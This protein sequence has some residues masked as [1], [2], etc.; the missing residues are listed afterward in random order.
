MEQ[1]IFVSKLIPPTPVQNYLRRANLLKKLSEWEQAK[2][3]ILTSSAGYGKTSLISQFVHDQK[4]VCTWYQITSD[5]DAI[6]PFLR[7]LIVSVQQQFP[8]FGQGMTGWDAKLKFHNVEE[9][10]QLSKQLV[11]E[12]HKINQPILVV[13]DD[14]HYVSHVFS[15]N[16]VLNQLLQFL[17]KTIHLMVATRKMPEWN[18]LLKLRMNNQLIECVEQEFI[19]SE[20]DIQFLFEAYFERSLSDEECEFVM[21]MTEGWAMAVLLLAY[22][23]KHTDKQLIDIANGSVTNF[24]AFLS[25]EVFDKLES[26]VQQLLLKLSVHQLISLDVLTDIYGEKW[27]EDVQNQLSKIAFVIPLAG[28]RKYRFHALFQQFLQQHLKA[29]SPETF[30]QLHEDAAIYYAN[31][32]LGILAVTHA[33]YLSNSQLLERLLLQFAP[34][35]IEAGQFDYL[36]ERIKDIPYANKGY[37]LLYYEGES[38]RYRAHYEKAKNAYLAC[39]EL[40]QIQQDSVFMM[41]AQFGLANIY[42]DTLQ[43]VFAEGHLQ[44]AILLLE[45]AKVSDEE[46]QKINIYYT[47]NLVNLGRAGEAQRWSEEQQLSLKLNNIDARLYLRQGQLELAKETLKHR[48]A[49]PFQWEEA[50]RTTDLLLVLIDVLTGENE[51]A[52]QRIIESDKEQLIDLPFTLAITKLRKGLALLNMELS[53]STLAKRCFD[54]TL[55][56]MSQIHVKR[57]KAECY[58]GLILYYRENVKEAKRYAQLGLK[59][60]NKVQDYWMSALL[61]SAL[62]KVLVE[63]G[64]HEEAILHGKLAYTY[65]ERSEDVYGQMVISFWLTTCFYEMQDVETAQQYYNVYWEFCRNDYPFFMKKRTLFGPQRPL[66]FLHLAKNVGRQQEV[67]DFLQQAMHPDESLKLA[68]FGPVQIMHENH[69]IQDKEW[70]R[71]KAKELFLYL[72]MHRRQFVSKQQ[73]CEAIWQNDEEAMTRDFKVVYNAMLKTLEPARTAREESN[74]IIR[75]QQLYKL[76]STWIQSDVALF[77]YYAQKGLEEKRPKVSN[78]WLKI[79]MSFAIAPFCSDNE[80]DW[81]L[82]MRS[83]YDEQIVKVSEKIAQN[84][85]RLEQFEQVIFWAEKLLLVDPGH[86]EGYRLMML[87]NYYKGNRR[88][89]LKVYDNC[90]KALDEQ[91]Q[92]A[93]MET[94]E[95]LYD[96]LLKM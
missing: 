45:E 30:E 76:D 14:Y 39:Y 53:D 31:G 84:Y 8:T 25:E 42:L 70:K 33:T 93:P 11:N 49:K 21:Q 17:P 62:T 22:Q 92:L 72:Y 80:R 74:F 9:L 32:Q 40:A 36:I 86:E 15:I 60:T 48:V 44:H 18:C 66:A 88:E 46:R 43:P 87:A 90:V 5:D 85:V 12:F 56:L 7:H 81:I 2:C 50:H 23:A 51:Q 82:P 89:A 96:L 59:E 77:D 29:C 38:Q 10:L 4:I 20:E 63:A 95:Q 94:T 64:Q 91:Y 6:F 67:L 65:F 71:M 83:F 41:R 58:M 19:F 34:Q 54:E 35:F 28:G 73:L 57:V 16:Y 47:E 24:F 37:Q 3:I 55:E 69:S 26:N 68:L 79:A 1:H 13:L 52:Y 27:G 75:R 61:L 78:E